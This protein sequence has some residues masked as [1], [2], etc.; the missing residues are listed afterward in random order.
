MKILVT[1]GAG[2]VGSHLIHALL[3][4]GHKVE[5]IDNLSTGSYD[6]VTLFHNNPNYRF[7]FSSVEH[8]GILEQLTQDCDVL[9]H[10][11]ASVG[12]KNIVENPI[13]C[14]ENNVF[15]TSMLLKYADKFGKR[16]IT[17]STSEVY[18]KATKFPFSE[19]DDIVLGPVHKLRWAYAAS[20]LIDDYLSRAYFEQKNTA[21]TI[22]RLFNTIGQRQVGHYGMVVPRFFEAAMTNQ[23]IQVHGSGEQTRCFTDVRD[24]VG[25]LLSVIDCRET[26]GE[27]IN[28]GTPN[29]ISINALAML[30]KEMTHSKSN[31]RH[32]SYESAYGKNFEDMNRRV[33]SNDKLT[34]LTGYKFKYELL[35]TLRWIQEEFQQKT[36]SQPKNEFHLGNKE[37]LL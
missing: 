11:A 24:V 29:E 19:E 1:G 13:H 25:A 7:H 26:H 22:V 31:I 4:S 5:C 30:I 16:I 34:Q 32:I 15:C 17:F 37:I 35:D 6:N 3:N 8:L 21:V 12:V 28:I 27:L 20:K 36:L 18:G 9:F 10:L 2:F 14:I 23:D 33:P